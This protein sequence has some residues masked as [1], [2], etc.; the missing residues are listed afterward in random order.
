MQASHSKMASFRRCKR[1]YNW[2]YNL[3]KDAGASI[4]QR[5]GS[6]G[7][8]ILAHWY[9]NKDKDN[10]EDECLQ[11]LDYLARNYMLPDDDRIRLE[12]AI[13]RYMDYSFNY[14][15]F[16]VLGTEIH[17]VKELGQHKIEGY[18]DLIAEYPDGRKYCID[19][20]FQKRPSV[21]GIDIDTQ[22]TMYLWLTDSD[23][24]MLNAINVTASKTTKMAS[25]LRDVTTRTPEYMERFLKDLESQL[26][27]MVEFDHMNNRDFRA[28]PSFSPNCKWDC[29]FYNTCKAFQDTGDI[30]LVM[31]LPMR[32][33]DKITILAGDES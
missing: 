15:V 28:Y 3:G 20:K 13:A 7:H 31:D 11:H 6:I 17:I 5:V 32:I 12:R 30:T 22:L 33:F 16:D 4:G 14:D 10:I 9:Q 26:D 27:E 2:T 18:V 1:Q 19:H 8:A 24:A 23:V 25:V 29:N 21:D